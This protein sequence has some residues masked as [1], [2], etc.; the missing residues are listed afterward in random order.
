M[1]NPFVPQSLICRE[2]ELERVCALLRQDS[3]F[4]VTGVPGIGRRTL[5]RSA[6]YQEGSR[7]L[8]ID[9]LRCRN[10]G[11]F[12]R[13]LADGIVDAFSEPSEIAQIQRWSQNQPL[14]V[15][16]T[17]EAEA[18]LVWPKTLGKEWPLFEDLLSL[19]QY[20]AEWLNCQ[21]VIIFHNFP[22]IRSW[23]RQGKWE[24]HLRQEIERQNRVSYALIATVAEPWMTASQLP[25]IALT[26][27]SDRELQPWVISTMA[28][29]G[30]KFDPES[31]ALE[32][33]LSYVQGHMKDAIT[34]AQR[35]WLG[36]NAIASPTPELIQAPLVHSTMLGLAQDMAV[37]F[38]AL[39][40]LLPSTQ[41]RVLESLA[42]DPT[43][44]PQSNA[45][46]KKHQ[47]SRGG[48]LQGALTSLE[49]KGLIYGPQFGYRIAL[50]LL[51]FWLKQ[52][53]R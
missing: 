35:L 37:V 41:A 29:A 21:V 10:A 51:D 40:L 16:Q 3:D 14:S 15:D 31:Q 7:C 38:E 18:R 47:L 52:R 17:L 34:L 42:L 19:P 36:C 53:L 28:T 4:V 9:L 48:G 20:L 2:S 25:V 23:D 32:L 1:F 44:S 11:Q 12:L 33:F 43:D 39:L 45:Y 13:F 5:I 24:S 6:A 50:P 49:Q 27:L 30:L 22:H 8:E 26:P 46:I